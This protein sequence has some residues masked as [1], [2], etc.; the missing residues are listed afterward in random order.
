MLYTPET[1]I[2]WGQEG[3][4][5]EV[6]AHF[7]TSWGPVTLSEERPHAA[8]TVPRQMLPSSVQFS[9]LKRSSIY[10][11][12]IR[13]EQFKNPIGHEAQLSD[14][15]LIGTVVMGWRHIDS[16]WSGLRNQREGMTGGMRGLSRADAGF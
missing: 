6:T 1:Q 15:K 16:E 2:R 5:C 7:C 4:H 11:N 14:L 12:S 3:S 8:L 13:K 9:T 10:I